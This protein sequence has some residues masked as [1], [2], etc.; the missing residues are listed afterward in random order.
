[1]LG[2][3]LQA[4]II[5]SVIKT[6]FLACPWDTSQVGPFTWSAIHSVSVPFFPCITFKQNNSGSKIW[7]GLMSSSLHW[8]LCLIT[9]DGLFRF[10][11]PT[12]QHFAQSSLTVSLGA[13]SIQGLWDFWK[14]LYFWANIHA[15]LLGSGLPYSGWYFLVPPI[16]I[17]N[18]WCPCF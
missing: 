5:S 3:C 12:L 18:S 4:Q 7:S 10:H 2:S 8:G 16:C 6:G 1:M 9:G 11:L 17:E 13:S 14:V 15:C